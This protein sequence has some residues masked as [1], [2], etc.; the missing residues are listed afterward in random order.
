MLPTSQTA[1]ENINLHVVSCVCL[2]GACL[3]TNCSC[4]NNMFSCLTLLMETS[5]LMPA[6]LLC[7]H[8]RY[9]TLT[10]T[11]HQCEKPVT[12]QGYQ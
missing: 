12:S 8:N 5:G 11:V 1:Q 9:S 4:D 10:L 7:Y 6:G 2:K 3:Y